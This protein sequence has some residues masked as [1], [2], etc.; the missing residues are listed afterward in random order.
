MINWNGQRKQPPICDHCG[1][2]AYPTAYNDA[3]EWALSWFCV[4]GHFEREILWPF[5]E[6]A[7]FTPGQLRTL[8]FS[9]R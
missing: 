4:C 3:G 2:A 7:I 8:G 6:G 5:S 1:K 9:I